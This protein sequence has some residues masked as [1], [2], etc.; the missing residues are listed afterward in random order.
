MGTELL[1]NLGSDVLMGLAQAAG[2]VA[3]CMAVVLLC[4]WFAVQRLHLS[5]DSDD[6]AQALRAPI[7]E[8]SKSSNQAL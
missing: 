8:S 2:A 6:V 7:G 4:R 5:A 3:L 1:N